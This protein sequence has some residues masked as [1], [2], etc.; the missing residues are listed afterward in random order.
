MTEQT[1]ILV[2]IRYPLTDKSARTLAA[3][4]RLADDLDHPHLTVLH[5]NLYQNRQQ[6]Q[7]RELQ[8]AV[9][10]IL[11]SIEP[12]VAIRRGFLL[13]QEILNE[14]VEIGADI[15]VVGASQQSLWRRILHRVLR[16]DLE[17][18]TFLFEKTSNET[19]IIEIDATAEISTA[20]R[21]S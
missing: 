9:S 19:E 12:S 10:S 18:G 4:E 6:T 3:A 2:A 15:I 7:R 14:A 17:I 8:K 21:A 11:T 16:N 5:V 1:K 20:E 13:E